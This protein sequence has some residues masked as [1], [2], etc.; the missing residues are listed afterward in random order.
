[1]KSGVRPTIRRN[2]RERNSNMN[3][4][5]KQKVAQPKPYAARLNALRNEKEETLIRYGIEIGMRLLAAS[6]NRD[7]HIANDRLIHSYARAAWL[8]ETEF[9]GKDP[10]VA[11]EGLFA[12]NDKA[13]GKGWE[14]KASA[15]CDKWRRDQEW[16]ELQPALNKLL[17]LSRSL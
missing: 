14:D 13:M 17:E 2:T 11:S 7:H 15:L 9:S 3:S 1:M 12:A 8:W 10:E 5:W 6:V 4:N 16:Q